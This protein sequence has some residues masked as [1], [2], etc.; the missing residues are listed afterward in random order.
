M[1]YF[2]RRNAEI[3]GKN[4]DQ[5]EEACNRKY[6]NINDNFYFG[7]NTSFSNAD[8]DIINSIVSG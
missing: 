6:Y 2:K 8:T 7:I 5:L 3:I 1:F 4:L